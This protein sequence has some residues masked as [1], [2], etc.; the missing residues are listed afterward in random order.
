MGTH[1]KMPTTRG[2]KE[3]WPPRCHEAKFGCPERATEKGGWKLCANHN[4]KADG[5]DW[6]NWGGPDDPTWGDFCPRHRPPREEEEIPEPAI[7]A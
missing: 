3:T 5:C 6:Q 1:A 7:P 2:N 4:C